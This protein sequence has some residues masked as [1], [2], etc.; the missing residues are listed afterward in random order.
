MAG[1]KA[2]YLVHFHIP[3]S[4]LLTDIIPIHHPFRKVVHSIE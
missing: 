3:E 1:T 4:T 2:D